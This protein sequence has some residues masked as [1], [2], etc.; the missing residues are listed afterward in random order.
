MMNAG[1]VIDAQLQQNNVPVLKPLYME[2]VALVERLHHRLLDVI[3]DEFARS[4]RFDVNSVQALLLF[5]IGDSEL[6]AAELCSR[7]YYL[8]SNISYNLKKLAEMDYIHH[9]R[10]RMD[11]RS[12]HVSL[13]AR[14]REVAAMVG[15]LYE[16]HL[17]SIEQVGGIAMDDFQRLNHALHRLDRFWSDQMLYRL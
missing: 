17:R 9:Q 1:R 15:A 13:T 7:G 16:R 4:D 6:T 14:G 11:R 2:A 12:V 5:N 10:S 3:K 8:G